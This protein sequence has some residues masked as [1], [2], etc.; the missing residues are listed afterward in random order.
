MG[1]SSALAKGYVWEFEGDTQSHWFAYDIST[2]TYLE[3]TYSKL[4]KRRPKSK[5]RQPIVN[6]KGHFQMQYVIDVEKMQQVG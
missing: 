1:R 4:M 3:E 2:M 5:K 6:M